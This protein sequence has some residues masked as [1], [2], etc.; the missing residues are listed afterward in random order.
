MHPLNHSLEF[1]RTFRLCAAVV[2]FSSLAHAVAPSTAS[3][4][5]PE[6]LTLKQ[7]IDRALKNNPRLLSAKTD[8]S[9]AKT[10]LRQAKSQFYPKVNLNMDYIRYR[11]ETIG[12][13]PPEM[14]NV[15]LETPAGSS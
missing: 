14:G 6:V 5:P 11:H 7:S 9:I 3:L 13:I 12:L 10:Q 15:V 2:F 8:L 1:R 4:T